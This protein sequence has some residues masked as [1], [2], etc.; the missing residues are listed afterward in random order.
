VSNGITVEQVLRHPHYRV[1]AAPTKGYTRRN[2][3]GF[4]RAQCPSNGRDAHRS[5]NPFIQQ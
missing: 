1:R 2:R 4:H 3:P 5:P